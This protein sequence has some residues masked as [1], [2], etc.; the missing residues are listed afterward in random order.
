MKSFPQ[1][2]SQNID[3]KT[4][5]IGSVTTNIV[6]SFIARRAHEPKKKKKKNQ[7]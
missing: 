4:L 1:I 3:Q 5:K 2:A 7:R 6:L